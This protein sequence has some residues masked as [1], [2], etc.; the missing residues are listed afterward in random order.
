MG[1]R[2]R[3]TIRAR[4][5]RGPPG[6]PVRVAELS[7]SCLQTPGNSHLLGERTNV[8]GGRFRQ[9]PGTGIIARELYR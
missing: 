6:A 4:R 7:L 2:Q 5:A 9:Q 1:T 3:R 8:P